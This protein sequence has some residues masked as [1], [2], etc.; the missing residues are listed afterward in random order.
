MKCLDCGK[1]IPLLKRLGKGEFCSDMHRFCSDQHRQNYQQ[2][3][4]QVALNRLMENA[5][6]RTKREG[7]L[8]GAARVETAH[9]APAQVPS[10]AC[11]AAALAPTEQS[12]FNPALGQEKISE[13]ASACEPMP[14]ALQESELPSELRDAGLPSE[15]A[16]AA[17]S[18]SADLSSTKTPTLSLP[19][20]LARRSHHLTGGQPVRIKITPP[21]MNHEDIPEPKRL[22]AP[23]PGIAAL[24]KVLS[25]GRTIGRRNGRISILSAAVLKVPRIGD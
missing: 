12:I 10:A 24:V 8:S 4:N 20:R 15:A 9:D 17:A 19:V 18:L 16:L 3:K 21:T 13:S 6:R 1:N 2:K 22:S 7:R 5:P 23:K 25:H 11:S 14:I